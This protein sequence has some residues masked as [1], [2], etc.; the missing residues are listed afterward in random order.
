MVRI[1]AENDD[2][3]GRVIASFVSDCNLQS[4]KDTVIKTAEAINH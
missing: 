2:I 1:N 4:V 3:I